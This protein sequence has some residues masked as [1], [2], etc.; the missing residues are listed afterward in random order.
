MDEAHVEHAVGLVEHEDRDL[1]KSHMAL[2]EEVEQASWRGDENIDASLERLHLMML[3]DAAENHRGGERQLP[4]VGRE[5]LA[6][7]AREL[8]RR[9]E[10]QRPRRSRRPLRMLEREAMQDGKSEGG[11]LAGP[12]LGDAEQVPSLGEER[13][14]L[15]LDRR[16]LEIFLG[17][18]RELLG[19]GE[20]EAVERSW[21]HYVSLYARAR[22]THDMRGSKRGL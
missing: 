13:D 7:L 19:L 14:R 21:C 12:R 9:R 15:R 17:L 2:V 18:Q 8:A 20:A 4:P 6:D 22:R 1:V 10:D 5:A 16:R 3:V 11:G